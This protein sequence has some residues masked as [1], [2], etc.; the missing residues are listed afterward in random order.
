[1][2]FKAPNDTLAH[3]LENGGGIQWQENELN[4]GKVGNW[5]IRWTVVKKKNCF[6]T[7]CAKILVRLVYAFLKYLTIHMTHSKLFIF[8]KQQGLFNFP[9]TSLRGF[10]HVAIVADNP[11]SLTLL[12][13][14]P[15]HFFYLCSANFYSGGIGKLLSVE[16]ILWFIIRKSCWQGC[17]TER[18]NHVV[19]NWIAFSTDN[20]Q[21]GII[22]KKS[23]WVSKVKGW[24]QL[25][26]VLEI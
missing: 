13:F 24:L 10:S 3:R 15:E 7:I 26:L 14:P 21:T 11:V 18:S 16:N 5:W 4:I 1:M 25:L 6:C 22:P 17:F 20:F 12:L 23:W 9:I 8:L 19:C 2:G